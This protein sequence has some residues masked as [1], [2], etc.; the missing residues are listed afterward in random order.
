[1]KFES[2]TD[3]AIAREIGQRIEQLRLQQNLT[4]Q[5]VADEVGLS[6]L[7][8]RKLVEGA[9]KFENVIAVLRVLGQLDL[10]ARFVPEVTS[11]PM[12]QLK[13]QG[14]KRQRASGSRQDQAASSVLTVESN[15]D[16]GLDW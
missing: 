12:Q 11:S 2:M 8:Y 9:G 3:R 6:R 14:R 15:D 4:Q 10:V 16:K 1:M 13:M 7:S 5:Y